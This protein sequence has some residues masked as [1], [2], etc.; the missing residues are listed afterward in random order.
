[1]KTVFTFTQKTNEYYIDSDGKKFVLYYFD[2]KL[3]TS[4]NLQDCLIYLFSRIGK[5]EVF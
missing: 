1:M 2:V 4:D 5:V 3:H